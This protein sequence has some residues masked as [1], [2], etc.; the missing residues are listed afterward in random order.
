V[1]HRAK[2]ASAQ[3][4]LV[5]AETVRRLEQN[6]G[7]LGTAAMASM[8]Q[9]LPW[10]RAL[11]AE[12]RSLDRPGR[13]SI[14]AFVDWVKHPQRRPAVAGEVRHGAPGAGPG[15]EPAADRGD[16]ADTIDVVEAQVDQLPRPAG[17]R[18]C[19]RRCSATPGRRL[20]AALSTPATPRPGAWD[21]RLEALVVDLN[22]RRE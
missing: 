21:A 7:A 11:P 3:S 17:G 5:R 6:M 22:P 9:R 20:G 12:N 13:G 19:A 14:G 8:E 16:G 10:F 4:G 2:P 1:P 18:D 15:G